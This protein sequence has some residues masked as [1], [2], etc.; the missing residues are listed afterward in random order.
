M[1]KA[2]LLKQAPEAGA[3][4]GIPGKS[5]K[6]RE[7]Q[8]LHQEGSLIPP[9]YLE[10]IAQQKAEFQNASNYGQVSPQAFRDELARAYK[11]GL[12][13][14]AAFVA[15]LEAEPDADD[16]RQLQICDA[17]ARQ[18]LIVC[19]RH[20][21]L[22]AHLKESVQLRYP[23]PCFLANGRF[24]VLFAPAGRKPDENLA[25][26]ASQVQSDSHKRRS[27]AAVLQEFLNDVPACGAES[28]WGICTNGRLWRIYR[29]NP[30]LSRPAYIE[31]NFDQIFDGS[32][33]EAFC[34][35]YALLHAS[36]FELYDGRNCILEDWR[37]IG[38]QIGTRIRDA[39]RSSVQQAIEI[40]AAGFLTHP[41]NKSLSRALLCGDLTAKTYYN[42]LLR[43]VYRLIFVLTAEERDLLPQK[44]APA[45]AREMFRL[46]YSLKRF[47]QR[48]FRLQ[49]PDRQSDL[50]ES[51]YVLFNALSTGEEKLALPALGGLFLS[52]QCA[53]LRPCK[54]YNADLLRALRCLLW[55]RDESD[56]LSPINWREMGSEELGSVYES[57]L[58]L[59]PQVDLGNLTFSF[60]QAQDAKGNERKT[61]GSYYTPGCLVDAILKST[62]EPLLLQ[63]IEQAKDK[64]QA[65]L[66]FK[67]C[68]PSCGSGHFLLA[69][70]RL[71]ASR[72]A[73][74]R[75][76]GTPGPDHYRAA[77]R[78]VI[79][80][81]LYGVDLNPM[82]VEL[83]R[84]SLW[85]EALDPQKPLSFLDAHIQC[86]NALLGATPELMREGI[87]AGAF[88]PCEGDDKKNLSALK[89]RNQQERDSP[90]Q[91]DLF[92]AFDRPAGLEQL[93]A[94]KKAFELEPEETLTQVEQKARD[95]AA[96]LQSDAYLAEKLKADCWC[97]AF[98]CEKTP[99]TA[100]ACPTDRA[101]KA[102]QRGEG[103][104][105]PQMADLIAET[106]RRH[107]LFHWHLQFPQIMAEGG[108]DAVLGNP[109]WET[110]EFREKEFFASRDPD[111]ANAS[112]TAKRKAAIQSLIE[113][114]PELYQL[115]LSEL[116][117]TSHARVFIS[118][119][120]RFPLCAKGKIN[121]YA[122]FAEHD[123]SLTS[124]RGR[125]G[126]VAPS[127]LASDATTQLF[128]KDLIETEEL[129]Y[130]WSFE[131]RDGIFPAVHR[132][133]NFALVGLDKLR[134]QK[135]DFAFY[136]HQSAELSNP[137]KHFTLSAEEFQLLNPNTLT[138]PTFRSRL[139]AELNKR[140]YRNAG[141]VLW[142]ETRADGN[143][144]Q[145]SF[146]QMLNMS[147]ASDLFMHRPQ[148]E[149][150][151][152]DGIRR[153]G[154]DGD[155]LP[156]YEAKLV[157]QFDHRFNTFTGTGNTDFEAVTEAQ[158]RDADF[159]T[160]T[161]YYVPA[162]EVEARLQ[163][164]AW[165]RGWLMGWRDI[166][167]STDA[168]T[169][170]ADVIPRVGCNHKWQLF[171]PDA[172][173]AL[174][175]CLLANL[176]CLALD[177]ACRCKLVGVDLSYSYFKQLPVLP[178][179]RFLD[180]QLSIEGE[181]LLPAIARR[182][183][184][185]CCTSHSLDAF[186]RDVCA[187]LG[188]AYDGP[189]AWDEPERLRLRA[190][191]DAA[192][193]CLYGVDETDLPLLFSSFEKTQGAPDAEDE[194]CEDGDEAAAAP[195]AAVG[196][197]EAARRAFLALKAAVLERWRRWRW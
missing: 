159:E 185:L 141:G 1:A 147:T 184:R 166:C 103:A 157:H 140:L 35:S 110:V 176:N 90:G 126:F 193:L 28:C 93:V 182:V 66:Q 154:P 113:N 53:H 118:E 132:S 41:K 67:V 16:Q 151:P 60:L 187:D 52:D 138:C 6:K 58:E 49:K 48:R 17:F 172:S 56:R 128:F 40:L 183:V 47:R 136:L 65:V 55:T 124:P 44:S 3:V 88:T 81:C 106:A 119:S 131:N 135:P 139:D 114:Q 14:Y 188:T 45:E 163:Q 19:Y 181:A 61:T 105:L 37:Q 174:C 21:L 18:I 89:K 175:A 8:A 57:L 102:L 192:F 34:A 59:C 155:L 20:M 86:G 32:H 165:N 43:F 117:N 190:D 69:A 125:A 76:G 104:L 153:T 42:E 186:G 169:V 75:A 162:R 149:S 123:R 195:V 142:N 24:P 31:F 4:A 84:V 191:L 99:D 134:G 158:H 120:G 92:D 150:L 87:P 30:S 79:A 71:I 2:K 11:A 46:G 133:F 54:L 9:A 50:F 10:Q 91:G 72:L 12:S 100:S 97:T 80:H 5:S 62:L 148:W 83:C 33:Y 108:F 25:L 127:G 70:G 156:L 161:R 137:Q 160:E 63:R 13:A 15:Q 82:A 64:V 189:Y 115:Y 116:S 78:D 177:Y 180:P 7:D 168:R 167:R 39:L 171:L 111:V 143:P 95:W 152:R 96:F 68:D 26:F 144:W 109:P 129:A 194:G 196:K 130:F 98:L 36:R 121:T 27:C 107:R 178:P 38:Q 23:L 101:F 85:M 29:Q 122:L 170:I 74:L 173:A 112:T 179:A 164:K 22:N 73:Y 197:A 146:M 145:L 94:Q 51:V 77:L